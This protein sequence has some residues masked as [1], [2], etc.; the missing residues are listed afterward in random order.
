[1]E[2][3]WIKRICLRSYAQSVNDYLPGAGSGLVVGKTLFT[4][5]S[6]AEEIVDYGW[7]CSMRLV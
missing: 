5:L 2:K 1:M 3:L 4:V 7:I 6:A